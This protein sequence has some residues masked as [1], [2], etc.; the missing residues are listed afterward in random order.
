[1]NWTNL[2]NASVED[3]YKATD[4]LL[5]MVGDADL[6]WKPAS[7]RNWMTTGQLAMHLTNACGFCCR[8]FLTGDWGLPEGAC[9]EGDGSGS[10]EIP[11]EAMLPPA[12]ALPTIESIAEARRLLAEDRL[13]ALRMIKE[14]GEE[15]LDTLM[16]AAPWCPD[17]P[18]PLGLQFLGMIHH[19]QSHKSQLFYYLKL[20]GRDVN[21]MHLWGM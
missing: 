3:T 5:A 2:L 13:L 8:G 18:Q 19:L 10:G 21:T 15:K 12:E 7:G 17:E 1:M 6:G 9:Q 4:A 14:A 11:M 20:M 16:V